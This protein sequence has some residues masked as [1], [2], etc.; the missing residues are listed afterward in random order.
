MTDKFREF[1]VFNHWKDVGEESFASLSHSKIV[2]DL[3]IQTIILL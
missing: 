1:T 2:Q 3:Q